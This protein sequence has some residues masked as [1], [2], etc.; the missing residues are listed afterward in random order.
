MAGAWAFELRGV[1]RGSLERCDDQWICLWVSPAKSDEPGT[2][3]DDRDVTSID[4]DVTGARKWN[5]SGSRS[6][7]WND[8]GWILVL[9][10]LPRETEWIFHGRHMIHVV[11]R[12]QWPGA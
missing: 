8:D 11:S 5:D 3:C 12:T 9:S 7:G 6:I 4:N 2:V 10:N 1:S